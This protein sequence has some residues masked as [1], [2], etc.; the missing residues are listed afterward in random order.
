MSIIIICIFFFATF[1]FCGIHIYYVDNLKLKPGMAL[2]QSTRSVNLL[3]VL[4]HSRSSKE[5][6]NR[7]LGIEA[8]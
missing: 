7:K 4:F 1:F 6:S 3:G 5:T 2:Y 8:Y